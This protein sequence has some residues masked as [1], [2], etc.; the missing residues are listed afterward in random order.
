M[1]KTYT[2]IFLSFILLLA[3]IFVYKLSQP[4]RKDSRA[5][6]KPSKTYQNDPVLE[7]VVAKTMSMS[8]N[9]SSAMNQWDW[10]SGIALAGLMKAYEI[11]KDEAILNYVDS[12]M[13]QRINDMS[14]PS[15]RVNPITMPR[16]YST[17]ACDDPKWASYSDWQHQEYLKYGYWHPNR[18]S[19]VWALTLL[20][21]YRPSKDYFNTISNHMDLMLNQACSENG[22]IL[23]TDRQVWDDTLAMEIPLMAQYGKTF[24]KPEVIDRAVNEYLI[25]AQ[26]LLDPQT[27]LWY[28]GYDFATKTNRT[29]GFWG[30]GNGW[31]VLSGL[32]LLDVLPINHSKRATIERILQRQL[33]TLT[34]LQ[35]ANGMWHTVV[36]RPD[37]YVETSG[38]S[39]ITAGLLYASKMSWQNPDFAASAQRGYRAATSKVSSDGTV[40]GVSSGTGLP[41]TS[42]DQYNGI[43]AADIKP[44]GQGM[45]LMMMAR[46]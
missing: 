37:F 40:T 44:Y 45:F 18:A 36:N 10:E 12:W 41:L 27:G 30:R 1:S 24:H 21:K 7:K 32:E 42:I 20:Y 34:K 35:N 16:M 22:T 4:T 23:H 25:H 38:T 13:K 31:V 33:T 11:N 15:G 9:P 3:S 8:N 39:A 2:V 5:A 26:Y 17:T 19:P 46:K 43:P 6:N 14:K 29:A 28:H